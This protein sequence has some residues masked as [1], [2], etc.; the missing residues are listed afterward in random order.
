M[1]EI[2][3]GRRIFGIDVHH[4]TLG[5][6][7]MGRIGEQVAK[8]A[9][10]GFDMNVFLQQAAEHGVRQTS[11]TFQASA[12]LTVLCIQATGSFTK[13]QT[14]MRLSHVFDNQ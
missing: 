2:R 12:M 8:R 14:I 9:A 1:D 7:G 13:Q 3:T 11:T 10:H 4:Q 5:I 6:I